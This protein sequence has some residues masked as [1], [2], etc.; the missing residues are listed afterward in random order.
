[1]RFVLYNYTTLFLPI[2]LLVTGA[3]IARAKVFLN[4]PDILPFNGLMTGKLR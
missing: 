2:E 1:M 3:R 4:Y